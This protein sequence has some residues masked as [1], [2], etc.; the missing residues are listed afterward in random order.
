MEENEKHLFLHLQRYTSEYG[1]QIIQLYNCLLKTKK[2]QC[3]FTFLL[4]QHLAFPYIFQECNLEGGREP[5]LTAE[6]Y[7][8]HITVYQADYNLKMSFLV[9]QKVDINL[10]Q[11]Y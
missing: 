9:T 2:P 10:A 4:K 6:F 11:Y 7:S 8:L 3:I 5:T 1:C